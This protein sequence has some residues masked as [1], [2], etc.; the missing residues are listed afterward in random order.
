MKR[1]NP[2][3]V[4]PLGNL[5]P[6]SEKQKKYLR[7]ARGI[8][9]P[10][11]LDGEEPE[12]KKVREFNGPMRA[13][14]KPAKRRGANCCRLGD[15]KRAAIAAAREAHGAARAAFFASLEQHRHE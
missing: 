6:D 9:K 3:K 10:F 15:E 8:R 14:W 1:F 12:V 2:W 7:K 11:A 5:Q 4:R 13:D